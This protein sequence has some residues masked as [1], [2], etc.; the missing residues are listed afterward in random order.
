MSLS[1]THEKLKSLG[2]VFG[3]SRATCTS[4]GSNTPAQDLTWDAV[5]S[6]LL[7][8]SSALSA[9]CLRLLQ[10]RHAATSTHTRMGRYGYGW[11]A[12]AQPAARMRITMKGSVL[13]G[14]GGK[15]G[16]ASKSD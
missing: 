10:M 2:A 14:G 6:R 1:T 9:D 7:L 12:S 5:V 15:E 3:C 16:G 4:S 8:L 13:G 11:G